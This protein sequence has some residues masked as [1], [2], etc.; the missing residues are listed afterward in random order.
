VTITNHAGVTSVS[1]L[2]PTLSDGFVVTADGCVGKLAPGKSCEIEVAYAPTALGTQLGTMLVNSNASSGQRPIKLKGKAFAPPLKMQPKA[3][4]FGLVRI[5]ARTQPGSASSTQTITLSNPSPVPITLTVAPAATPP[6]NVITNTCAT[7]A[8]NGG[9]CTISVEF[10][11]VS[12]GTFQ[13]TLEIRDNGA[14]SPQ[15][16]KL[17]GSA[18]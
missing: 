17:N 12:P 1:F 8:P 11:P 15:H 6:Y 4:D 2:P 16:I 7:L 10:A 9:T 5:R 13:G 18:N 14:K 3:L